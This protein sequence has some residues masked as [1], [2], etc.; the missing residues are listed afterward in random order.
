MAAGKLGTTHSFVASVVVDLV[1]ETGAALMGAVATLL[2]VEI[3]QARQYEEN[4]RLYRAVKAH[5]GND[6]SSSTNPPDAIRPHGP[7]PS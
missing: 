5:L 1:F 6:A 2:F 3:A 7:G 4:K